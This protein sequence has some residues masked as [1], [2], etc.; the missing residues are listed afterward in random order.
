LL[1]T[2]LKQTD[3]PSPL[4]AGWLA[5]PFAGSPPA[6]RST[7]LVVSVCVSRIQICRFP[8]RAP[9]SSAPLANTRKRPS[10]LTVLLPDKNVPTSLSPAG[11]SAPRPSGR[12]S[13]SVLP[14][15]APHTGPPDAATMQ[16]T[17]VTT[18]RR[19]VV[20]C[21]CPCSA[22][23][24]RAGLLTCGAPAFRKRSGNKATLIAVP[25]HT[26]APACLSRRQAAAECDNPGPA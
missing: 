7:R 16:T 26:L 3:P 4:I 13:K 17:T 21:S 12:L 15:P 14:G 19:M 24:V 6:A 1:A 5:S 22:V 25:A 23:K 10:P 2:E 20:P 18:P 8:S 9:R 11:T